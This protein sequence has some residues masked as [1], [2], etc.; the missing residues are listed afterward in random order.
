MNDTIRNLSILCSQRARI[1]EI[2]RHSLPHELHTRLMHALCMNEHL[3]CEL[4][5]PTE[6]QAYFKREL[7]NLAIEVDAIFDALPT[8]I[9]YRS[10]TAE[11]FKGS[12]G[13]EC[14]V[15]DRHGNDL[16]WFLY[17]DNLAEARAK[18]ERHFDGAIACLRGFSTTGEFFGRM[19]GYG[20]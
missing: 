14:K 8:I 6:S 9:F 13:Y 7:A 10:I 18:A 4:E 20:I 16:R 11:I 3:I 1:D 12:N 17:A 15:T 2:D 19:N 5:Y